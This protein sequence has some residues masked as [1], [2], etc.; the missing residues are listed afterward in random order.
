MFSN[1]PYHFIFVVIDFLVGFL[2]WFE[3]YLPLQAGGFFMTEIL[4]ETSQHEI[5]FYLLMM[6]A[7]AGGSRDCSYC[8]S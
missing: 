7:V 2:S 6:R 1:V 4:P 3:F 5:G 8:D